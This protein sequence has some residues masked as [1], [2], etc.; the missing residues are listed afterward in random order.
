MSK[1]VDVAK[2][3]AKALVLLVIIAVIAIADGLGID[4]GLEIQHYLGLLVADGLVWAVPNKDEDE[5]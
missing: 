3:N 4:T 1:L 5:A 2:A